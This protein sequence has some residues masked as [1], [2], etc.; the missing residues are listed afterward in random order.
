MCIN[1]FSLNRLF[2][3]YFSYWKYDL[4]IILIILKGTNSKS[5]TL[6]SLHILLFYFYYLRLIFNFP[7]SLLLKNIF[8]VTVFLLLWWSRRLSMSILGPVQWDYFLMFWEDVFFQAFLSKQLKVNINM[9][10]CDN[11]YL[12]HNAKRLIIISKKEILSI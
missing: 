8:N 1:K 2:P 12:Y 11:L 7:S 4:K 10:S 6:L 5:S 3:H 9:R